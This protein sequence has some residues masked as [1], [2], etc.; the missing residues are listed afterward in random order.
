M[1]KRVSSEKKYVSIHNTEKIDR[2]IEFML[3]IVLL[4]TPED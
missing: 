3:H 4:F 1:N 2:Y